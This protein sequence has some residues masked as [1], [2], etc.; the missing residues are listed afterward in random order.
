MKMIDDAVYN[1]RK[2]IRELGATVNQINL[3]IKLQA[4]YRGFKVR[5]YTKYIEKA[6]EISLNAE[7]KYLSEPLV[8]SY[9]F[10]YAMYCYVVRLDYDR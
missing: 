4:L 10:N 1:E 3:T 6:M 7:I 9:L 8:D 2:Q 5:S